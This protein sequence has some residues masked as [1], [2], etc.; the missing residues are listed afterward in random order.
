MRVI[1]D[2][3]CVGIVSDS[4]CEQYRRIMLNMA[5]RGAQGILLGC[6]EIDVLI[7]PQDSPVPLLDTPRLH[8]RHAVELALG[9]GYGR[10]RSSATSHTG[11]GA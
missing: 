5:D 11:D 7:G 1:Y 6:T 2:E 9:F 3:L 8:A 4:S 10:H